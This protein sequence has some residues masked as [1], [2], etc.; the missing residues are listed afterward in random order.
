MEL[1]SWLGKPER[2]SKFVNKYLSVGEEFIGIYTGALPTTNSYGKTV[3]YLFLAGDREMIFDNKNPV[4]AEKFVAIPFNS[5]VKIRKFS[6]DGRI[7][8]DVTPI[9]PLD[10]GS[11]NI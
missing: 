8:Y 6:K 1:I 4:I 7:L 10:K 11:L 5:K 3:H 9:R 2:K